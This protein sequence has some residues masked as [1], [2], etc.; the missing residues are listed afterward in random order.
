M[1]TEITQLVNKY[2]A[3]SLA[4][5]AALFSAIGWGCNSFYQII[6]D[7]YKQK[8]ELK[9]FLWKE[10]IS[11]AKKASEFYLEYLGFI[12]LL[13][14][15]LEALETGKD[16]NNKVADNLE[17]E[18]QLL[19]T[20]LKAF[21]HFEH[22]HINIF[23]DFNEK[24]AFEINRENVEILG[25]MHGL[26]SSNL[27]NEEFSIKLRQCITKIKNNYAELAQINGGFIVKVRNDISN[28]L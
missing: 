1:L 17:A 27:S 14:N 21:P 10:K 11:A 23:Y 18:V 16:E 19:S 25:Q 22:H 26:G 8:R 28:Y 15:Q 2:P 20:K 7:N 12:N 4:I 24:R 13:V 5:I 3:I 6:I 9:A